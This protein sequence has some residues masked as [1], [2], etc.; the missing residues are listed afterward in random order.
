MLY[1][2]KW[3]QV[4]TTILDYE[5]LTDRFQYFLCFEFC[6]EIDVFYDSAF[7]IVILLIYTLIHNEA[8]VPNKN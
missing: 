7:V 2:K 1:K 8:L 6:C 4:N 3:E 5:W